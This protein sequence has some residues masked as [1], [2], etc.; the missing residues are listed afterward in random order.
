MTRQREGTWPKIIRA[1]ELLAS[2]KAEIDTYSHG[3]P[4]QIVGQFN[5]DGRSYRASVLL[6]EAPSIRLSVLIGEF[7]YNLRSGLDHL[8][9]WLVRQKGSPV[10]VQ[11]PIRDSCL[12]KQGLPSPLK[13]VERVSVESAAVIESVQPYH[14]GTDTLWHPLSLLGHICNAD[15]HRNLL[16]GAALVIDTQVLLDFGDALFTQYAVGDFVDG[17]PLADFPFAEPVPLEMQSKVKVDGYCQEVRV[18][19]AEAEPPQDRSVLD[20]LREILA[21]VTDSV[22]LPIE[23]AEF[24]R[25]I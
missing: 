6:R 7:A 16:I 22:V 15:K 24:G 23:R 10:D 17:A 25:D 1:E 18:I 3:E 8:M 12:N 2:I 19:F 5:D 13:F 11:F 20:V 4:Y 9:D 14:R 21:Y